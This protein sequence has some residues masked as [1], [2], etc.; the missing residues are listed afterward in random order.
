LR[1]IF[2]LAYFLLWVAAGSYWICTS[3]EYPLRVA[4]LETITVVPI[5]ISIL[6]SGF[7]YKPKRFTWI[8]KI[9]PLILL[10]ACVFD[11]YIG[12]GSSSPPARPLLYTILDGLVG[13]AMIFPAFYLPFSFAYS[14][15]LP[16]T[17]LSPK[18]LAVSL[19]MAAFYS[20]SDYIPYPQPNVNVKVNY[21]VEYNKTTD[22]DT[23]FPIEKTKTQG[24]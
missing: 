13:S 1:R 10:S 7:C 15:T 5:A 8:W 16:P 3:F 23:T 14:K 19:A 9:V 18:L 11:W 2:I 22:A 20:F 6:F 24:Q 12:W 21:V 17:K 4:L